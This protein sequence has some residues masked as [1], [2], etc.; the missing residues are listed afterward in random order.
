MRWTT[1][2][3]PRRSMTPKPRSCAVWMRE[4]VWRALAL[5]AAHQQE[6]L[7]LRF[8]QTTSLQDTAKQH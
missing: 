8:G 7:I 6:V 1:T 5:L 4:R 3:S 2:W